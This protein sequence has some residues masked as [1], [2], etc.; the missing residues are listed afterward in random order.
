[1]EDTRRPSAAL[2]LPGLRRWFQRSVKRYGVFSPRG[3]LCGVFSHLGSMASAFPHGYDGFV[4][5]CQTL[6]FISI[7]LFLSYTAAFAVAKITG[8]RTKLVL[9]TIKG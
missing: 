3:L 6:K 1:M 8:I 7:I 2:R 5:F 4:A 9:G